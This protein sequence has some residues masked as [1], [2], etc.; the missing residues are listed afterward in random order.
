VICSIAEVLEDKGM[1]VETT[2]PPAKKALIIKYLGRAVDM[3]NRVGDTFILDV[4][5]DRAFPAKLVKER[6]G[7]GSETAKVEYV[8]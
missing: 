7:Q 2:V 3:A 1:A 4:P 8:L 5:T 6:N